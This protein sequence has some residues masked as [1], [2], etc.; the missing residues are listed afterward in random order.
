M[1]IDHSGLACWH[2]LVDWEAAI[3]PRELHLSLGLGLDLHLQ[4]GFR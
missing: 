1:V 3:F 4:L 2:R